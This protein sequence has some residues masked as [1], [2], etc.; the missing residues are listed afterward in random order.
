MNDPEERTASLALR[1]GGPAS[2]RKAVGWYRTHGRLNCG[3]QIMMAA[4]ALAAY[5]ADTAAGKDALLIC[6]TTEIADALNQRIHRDTIAADAPTVGGPWASNRRRRPHHQPPKRHHHRG[7]QRHRPSGA[8]RPGTQR[9]P[10]ARRR[11]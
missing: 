11:D 3:D 9:Q 4:D 2:V 10:L 6:D 5:R 8:T 7:T 1:N